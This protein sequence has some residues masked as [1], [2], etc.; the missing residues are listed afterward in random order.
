[1]DGIG[2]KRENHERGPEKLL[3]H[4]SEIIGRIGS[5]SRHGFLW[6]SYNAKNGS[7]AT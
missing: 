7:I 6:Q 4:L 5:A 3:E 1:M 2:D